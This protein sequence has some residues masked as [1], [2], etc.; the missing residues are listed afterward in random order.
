MKK[1]LHSKRVSFEYDQITP[2]IYIGTNA[3]CR[4]HFDEKLLKK[5]IQADVSLDDKRIDQPRGVKYFLWLPTKNHAAPTQA[6]LQLG[7]AALQ[8]LVANRMKVYVHCQRGHGRAPTLVAAYLI[9]EGMSLAKAI[10]FVRKKRPSMHLETAQVA[11]LAKF[12]NKAVK[13]AL[14]AE[15]KR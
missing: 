6:Q 2:Y 12:E 3:C 5:G 4:P 7:V 11:A 9:A 1:E 14:K 10:A 13:L 15:K 8:M